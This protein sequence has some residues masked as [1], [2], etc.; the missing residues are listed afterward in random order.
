[1][2][3]SFTDTYEEFTRFDHANLFVGTLGNVLNTSPVLIPVFS[4]VEAI[5][6]NDARGGVFFGGC[7]INFFINYVLHKFTQSKIDNPMCIIYKKM[8]T[9]GMPSLHTQTIGFLV[10]FIITM[11]YIKNHFRILA[12]AFC[13]GICIIMYLQRKASKCNTTLQIIIG[14]LLGLLIGSTWAWIVSPSFTPWASASDIDIS[15]FDK[16]ECDKDEN[17]DYECK[18]YK[19]GRII[20]N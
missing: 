19:N 12:T 20:Q 17:E 13:I 11:M 5:L 1:M 2:N 14:L 16:R 10:G 6:F 7:L 18:A 15:R 4:L 8:N 3:E 9:S